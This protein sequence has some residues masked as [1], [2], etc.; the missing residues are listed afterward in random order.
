MVLQPIRETHFT[1]E[2]EPEKGEMLF[3]VTRSGAF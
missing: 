1:P 2:P 3:M